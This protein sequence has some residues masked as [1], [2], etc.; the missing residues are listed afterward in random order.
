MRAKAPSW[1]W[2]S[3]SVHCTADTCLGYKF[4]NTAKVACSLKDWK[5]Y[6]PDRSRFGPVY[7]GQL[8]LLAPRRPFLD[9]AVHGVDK[10][11]GLTFNDADC[12]IVVDLDIGQS[13]VDW[14]TVECMKSLSS[15]EEYF[16]S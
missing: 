3:L 16:V 4:S 15:V 2:G 13:D 9:P 8:R 1:S 10:W 12:Y 11:L 6:P 5:I 7:A 14:D